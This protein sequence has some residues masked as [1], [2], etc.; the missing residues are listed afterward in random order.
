MNKKMFRILVA[1]TLAIGFVTLTGCFTPA[2]LRSG[3]GL[4]PAQPAPVKIK[5]SN[6]QFSAS[7]IY[8][9]NF[10]DVFQAAGDVAFRQGLV[11]EEKNEKTGTITGNGYWQTICGAGPCNM[12]ITY[13]IYVDEVD[14]KP[15]SKL[16]FLFD[17][18]TTTAWGGEAGV[19]NKFLVEVQKILA[20]Y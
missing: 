12:N 15:T 4:Y 3:I 6:K 13:V 8:P 16:T 2:P 14:D 7:R 18:Y 20:T 17:R 1:L 19:A 5:G 10:D 11:I 9:F